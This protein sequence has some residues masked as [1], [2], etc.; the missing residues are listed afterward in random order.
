MQYMHETNPWERG[1]SG[2]ETRVLWLW[3]GGTL[4]GL[5]DMQREVRGE[6]KEE[7]KSQLNRGIRGQRGYKQDH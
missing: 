4:Q 6:E 1:V 7:R 5:S 3:V 2:E